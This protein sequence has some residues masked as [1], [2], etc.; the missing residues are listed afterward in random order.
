V[1]ARGSDAVLVALLGSVM[2]SLLLHM[3]VS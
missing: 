1:P 2:R 3:R